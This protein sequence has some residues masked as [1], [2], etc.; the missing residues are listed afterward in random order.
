MATE[1]LVHR[2]RMSDTHIRELD[3]YYDKGGMN[4]WDYS[5]KP[6]G[7]YFS[8]TVYEQPVGSNMRSLTIGARSQQPGVGYILVV[9]LTTY[10]PKAL[11]EVRARVETHAE[12]IHTL[13]A[14]GDT[15]SMAKLRA[16]LTGTEVPQ[17]SSAE[18]FA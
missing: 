14:V 13:C 18:V 2:H 8:S 3:V 7:I 12:A 1:R 4:Y 17:A 11:R 5:T 10:R 16:I 15:A 6:K 9:P